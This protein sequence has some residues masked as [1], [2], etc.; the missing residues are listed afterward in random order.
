[1]GKPKLQIIVLF[2]GLEA[3]RNLNKHFYSWKNILKCWWRFVSTMSSKGNLAWQ[4]FRVLLLSVFFFK[5]SFFERNHAQKR[6]Y[7]VHFEKEA[8]TFQKN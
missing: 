1:M 8:I 4:M 3:F 7:P 2:Q 5:L 6:V